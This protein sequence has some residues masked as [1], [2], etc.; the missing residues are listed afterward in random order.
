MFLAVAAGCAAQ[1]ARL[2]EVVDRTLGN[3]V[4]VLMVERPGTGAVRAGLFLM[5]GRA[6]TGALPPGAADLLAYSLFRRLPAPSLGRDLEVTLRQEAAA[7]EDLR[8]ERL[9]QRRPDHTASP[10]LTSLQTMHAEALKTIQARLAPTEAWDEVDA[11]GG[12]RRAVDVTAD[13]LAFGVDLPAANLPGWLRLEAEHVAAPS[14][15]RFPLERE[16]LLQALD[17]GEP[18]VAASLSVLLSMALAGRAYA[19]ASEFQRGDVEAIT[20]AQL[21]DLARA[22][23]VPARMLLVLAG[24]LEAATLTPV[25]ERT[26]GRIKGGPAPEAPP[27]RDDNPSSALESPAGRKLQVSTSGETRVIFGWRVPR[28]NHPDGP[29][30]QALAQVL[31]G[32]PSA[33][34]IQGLVTTRGLARKLTLDVGVPG[35]RDVNLFVIN[36]EPAPG[37]ALG[38]LEQAI[39]GEILRLQREPLAEVEVRWAQNQLETRQILLQEDGA[40]LV[41]ALGASHCQS[42]DWRTAFRAF[43]GERALRATDIQAAART[44]LVP[45]RMTVALFG[46]DPLLQPM[47]RIEARLLQALTVLVQRRLEDPVAAQR[48][49]REA[50]RQLRMLSPSER[51]QTLK[52]LE[53]QVAP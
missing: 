23:L 53:A 37:H 30:L 28:S 22:Q 47:D 49:L 7:F 14:L 3:G 34:L 45:A 33:R 31:A 44:Y 1:T 24:D 16:R 9:R 21:G 42:G 8:L 10:E 32:S 25:L 36:A 52:L 26:F 12:T 19:Q 2:P 40:A 27:Y 11:L 6:A 35:E 43:S 13:Y 39:E 5:G 4:K 41:Q 50:I 48:I 46:P 29:A 51:E 15:C 38:E 17:A 20:L 18:P